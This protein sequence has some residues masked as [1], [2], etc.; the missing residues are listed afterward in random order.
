MLNVICVLFVSDV[1][2]VSH[3]SFVPYVPNLMCIFFMSCRPT[4]KLFW[5]YEGVKETCRIG[6]ITIVHYA[7]SVRDRTFVL[8]QKCL[9]KIHILINYSKHPC[10]KTLA[11]K[12][13]NIFQVGF[14][15]NMLNSSN[16]Q[17]SQLDIYIESKT[18]LRECDHFMLLV[19][20]SSSQLVKV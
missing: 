17:V 6:F 1:L 4:R 18:V 13:I 5:T 15:L 7:L 10:C 19:L 2:N 3:V 9:Q 16:N 12:V 20:I 14:L 8:S 11:I